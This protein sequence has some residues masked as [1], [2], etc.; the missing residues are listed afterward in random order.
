VTKVQ[1]LENQVSTIS[2][3]VKESQEA[4]ISKT[5]AAK[6]LTKELKQKKTIIAQKDNLMK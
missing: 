6:L 2:Q 3:E 1:K 5:E 4:L